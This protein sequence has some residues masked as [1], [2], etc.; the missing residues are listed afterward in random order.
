MT[1]VAVLGTGTMGAPM[2]RNLAKAGF[3]VCV[4][5]RTRERAK[6]LQGARIRAVDRVPDAIS[7]AD[8]VITMLTDGAAVE[9]AVGGGLDDFGAAVWLQMSTLGVAATERLVAS[10]KAHAITFVDAPVLGTRQPAEQGELTILASGPQNVRDRCAP[11]FDAVGSRTFWLGAAGAGTRMKLVTNA[12][13]VGLVAALAESIALAEG[14]DLDPSDF[15]KILEG[16][17][18]GSPYAQLKG[19]AMIERDFTP[20][21]ALRLARKDVGL[22][23]EAAERAGMD[24]VIT[25]AVAKQFDDAIEQGHGDEDIAAARYGVRDA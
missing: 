8:F 15:L 25:R 17:P 22:V 13:L 10:A 21:F 19:K 6:A 5:N 18:L 14:M 12:W 9:G 2:A 7:G 4:W 24:P 20:S 1:V 16:H 11:P 23:L 3:E